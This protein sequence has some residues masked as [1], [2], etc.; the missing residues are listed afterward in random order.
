VS[1]NVQ[2]DNDNDDNGELGGCS[3]KLLDASGNV[4]HHI[5]GI[6]SAVYTFYDTEGSYS[7]METNLVGYLDVSDIDDVNMIAV[8]VGF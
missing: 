1:G 8:T 7:V 2:E 3:I 5:D 6:S 4:D